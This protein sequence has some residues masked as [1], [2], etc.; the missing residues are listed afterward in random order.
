MIEARSQGQT[1]LNAVTTT[2]ASS[3]I[4]LSEMSSATFYITAA[5]VTSGGTLSIQVKSPSGTWY[6]ADTQTITA[7]GGTVVTL[8]GAFGP[9][10]ANLTARTDGTYTVEVFAKS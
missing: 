9:A 1:L 8:N 4:D 10:R 7:N 5:S 6:N 3:E 2:G